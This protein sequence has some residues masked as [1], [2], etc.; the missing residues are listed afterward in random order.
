MVQFAIQEHGWVKYLYKAS[1]DRAVV[2]ASRPDSHSPVH[3]ISLGK[4]ILAFLPEEQVNSILRRR[5]IPEQTQNTITDSGELRNALMTIHERRYALDDEETLGGLRCVVA[6]IRDD[7]DVLGAVNITV[8]S[9]RFTH[10]R[11]KT[12]SLNSFRRPRT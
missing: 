4:T 8:P 9:G 10:D 12:S 5:R 3:P 1:G 2:T 11:L 6:P 7:N